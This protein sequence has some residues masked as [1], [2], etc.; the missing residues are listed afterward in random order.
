VYTCD[1]ASVYAFYT[2]IYTYSYICTHVSPSDA[3]VRQ[4]LLNFTHVSV[5]EI[6]AIMSTH[7][8]DEGKRTAQ[9]RLAEQLTCMVHGE[10]ALVTVQS[11]SDALFH[12]TTPF[13]EQKGTVISKEVLLEAF[14]GVEQTVVRG[15]D[16]PGLTVARALVRAY[17]SVWGCVCVCEY[18]CVCVCVCVCGCVCVC[19]KFTDT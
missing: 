6:D 19:Y 4:L 13:H 14:Q 10:S 5:D 11:I 7:T 12:S 16:L 15:E 1:H 18:V 2:Y 8:L 9:R 3:D 17:V